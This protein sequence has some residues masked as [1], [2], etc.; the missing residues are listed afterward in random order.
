MS[1]LRPRPWAITNRAS[2]GFTLLE[3]LVA[4]S[5]LALL[6]TL[7]YAAMRT[8]VHAT[9]SG[10]ATIARS[11]ELR[12]SQ[13]FLRRQLSQ[14][15]PVPYDVDQ[16]TGIAYL[17][18]GGDDAI[19]FVAT[20]PGYLSRGGPHVQRLALV[21]GQGGLQL[22]FSHSQLNGYD[23]MLPL[24][25]DREPVVLLAGIARGGFEYRQREV[26]GLLGPWTREWEQ[27]S[28]L[29]QQLRLWLEFDNDDP[30]HWPELEVPMLAGGASGL[31]MAQPP[32]RERREPTRPPRPS[33]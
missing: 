28:M 15:L 8:A 1:L 12:T 3:V 14:A 25:G 6:L 10:E 23:P 21:R 5:L 2:S 24:G 32:R 26:D 7:A 16:N 13:T 9:R 4:I 17:F 22:E 27:P 31:G 11:E 19:R 33:Q 18:E 30:R 20:M 29:P